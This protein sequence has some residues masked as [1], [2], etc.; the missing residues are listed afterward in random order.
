MEDALVRSLRLLRPGDS[1]RREGYRREL[2]AV[3]AGMNPEAG[4]SAYAFSTRD[5]HSERWS[6]LRLIKGARHWRTEFFLRAESLFTAGAYL[7]RS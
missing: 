1:E 3:A 4:S 2:P 6:A 7:A 5:S